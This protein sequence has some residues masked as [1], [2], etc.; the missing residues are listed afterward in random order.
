MTW[1]VSIPQ[2]L[3]KYKTDFTEILQKAKQYIPRSYNGLLK[4]DFFPVSR[5]QPIECHHYQ[6]SS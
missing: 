5:W 6:K 2:L 4:F 3:K 1:W